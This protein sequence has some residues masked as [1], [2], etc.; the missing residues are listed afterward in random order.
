MSELGRYLVTMR[1]RDVGAF[2]TP[3]LRDV[4]LTAPY[5]HDGS[6]KT[7]LD[8]VRFY[9]RGGERNPA[10]DLRVRTLGL[11]EEGMSALVEFLRA[12]TSDEV[13]RLAQTAA[14]RR[15]RRRRCRHRAAFLEPPS[16][17]V[18]A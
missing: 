12:L 5:M 3:A 17:G 18:A 6:V 4:E 11:T 2:K 14:P 9:N 13:L 1:P 8:A 15:V 10:L 16:R 7:L